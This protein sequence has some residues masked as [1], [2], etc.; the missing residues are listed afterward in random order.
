MKKNKKNSLFKLHTALQSIVEGIPTNYEEAMNSSDWKAAMDEEMKNLERNQTYKPYKINNNDKSIG[1]R[2]QRCTRQ[3]PIQ[4]PEVILPQINKNSS[5]LKM[6][7][8]ALFSQTIYDYV[9]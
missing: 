4:S 7:I 6:L 3:F 5:K 8:F 1:C 2:W 9:N